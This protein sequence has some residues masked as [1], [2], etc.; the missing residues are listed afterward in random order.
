MPRVREH[1]VLGAR[2]RDQGAVR[3]PGRRSGG[4]GREEGQRDGA[5]ALRRR[6]AR[7]ADPRARRGR[8][9]AFVQPRGS[10]RC[11]APVPGTDGGAVPAR[12]GPRGRPLGRRRA[13]G[14]RRARRR[15][16]AGADHAA[17]ARP[18]RA[19]RDAC[20][21]GRRQAQRRVDLPRSALGG[22]GRR[23]VGGSARLRP[24]RGRARPD[25]RTQRGQPA[26]RGGDRPHADRRRRAAGDPG[27]AVGGGASRRRR[28]G[29]PVDPGVD[30][31]AA[32]RAARRREDVPAGCGRGRPGL[33]D[34]GGGDARRCGPGRVA[35][36]ARPPAREGTGAAARAVELLRRAGVLVPSQPDPR[37]RV[38]LAAEGPPRRE[39]RAGGTMG[40]GARRR[41]GGGDRGA[42]R[43]PLRGGDAL[44][45][46]ARRGRRR[47]RRDRLGGV[48]MGLRRRRS[49]RGALATRGGGALVPGGAD[50]VGGGGGDDGRSRVARTAADGGRSGHGV[51]RR[52]RGRRA[53]RPRPLHDARRRA[54]RRMGAGATLVRA[55]PAGE[56]RGGAHRGA[57]GYRAARAAR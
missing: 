4:R 20:G 35:R 14:L 12:A 45:G 41:P 40:P 24:H 48:P 1:V 32:R 39:A 22:R 55:L 42:D 57:R 49:H 19:L 17:D 3:D 8:R 34:R 21:V 47:T 29:A 51:G 43:H 53:S 28:R 36:R 31:R 30:R 11:L 33:L 56:G 9:G 18:A 50:V 54:E 15:S 26:L 46:R 27:V 2:R 44:P 23:H 7:T 38:R 13:P 25:R 52:Q 10:V 37:R 16:G 5:R 6:H